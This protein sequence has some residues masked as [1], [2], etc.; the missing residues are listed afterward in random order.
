[1]GHAVCVRTLHHHAVYT[2]FTVHFDRSRI[3]GGP[4]GC[5]P[6]ALRR[7]W[8]N[9]KYGASKR[10]STH[11]KEVFRKF[12]STWIRVLKNFRHPCRRPKKF[13]DCRSEGALNY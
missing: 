13:V 9:R 8:N 1:M 5:L 12:F 6:E 2:E 10:R 3:I 4:A 7:R 11:A